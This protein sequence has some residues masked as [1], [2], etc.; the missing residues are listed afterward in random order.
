VCET[1]GKI[2]EERDLLLDALKEEEWLMV[3]RI[4]ESLDVFFPR[5]TETREEAFALRDDWRNAWMT[6]QSSGSSMSTDEVYRLIV[7]GGKVTFKNNTT[8]EMDS[9]RKNFNLGGNDP[10]DPDQDPGLDHRLEL[11]VEIARQTYRTR[12]TESQKTESGVR[13][14]FPDG[15]LW[16]N[17]I[18]LFYIKAMKEAGLTGQYAPVKFNRWARNLSRTSVIV[19]VMDGE[20]LKKDDGLKIGYVV[21]DP[22]SDGE[23]TVEDGMM[24]IV[25]PALELTES[26]T[27][28]D[29]TLDNPVE[30]DSD[31]Y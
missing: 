14:N 16:T 24:C 20:V 25:E 11:A 27:E 28:V 15:L 18:G 13:R 9:V 3:R 5:T 30:F 31:S 22:V 2:R 7:N 29:E 4:P 6:F 17:T 19:N 23:Y 10:T 1:L 12:Y 8:I 26:A 21:G